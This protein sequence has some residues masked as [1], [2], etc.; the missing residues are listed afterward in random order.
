MHISKLIE[1]YLIT[2]HSGPPLTQVSIILYDNTGQIGIILYYP[3][4][5][6]LPENRITETGK[7]FFYKHFSH[8]SFD[9]DILRNEKPVY[10]QYNDRTK[11]GFISTSGEPVGEEEL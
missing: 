3:D 7:V 10:I 4:G 9:V 1:R 8:V 2:S 6:D 11:Y 5:E